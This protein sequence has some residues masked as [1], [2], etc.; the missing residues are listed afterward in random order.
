MCEERAAKRSR[1]S[2]TE[3]DIKKEESPFSCEWE[4]S[5]VVLIVEERKLHVHI[6]VL[7]LHSFVFKKMFNSSKFAESEVKEV[8]LPKKDYKVVENLLM[9]IYQHTSLDLCK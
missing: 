4:G 5:D 6:L 8:H 7:S 1:L 9:I 2:S 3:E